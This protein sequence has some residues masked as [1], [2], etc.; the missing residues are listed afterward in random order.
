LGRTQKETL[1]ATV[2]SAAGTPSGTVTFFDGGRTLGTGTLDAAGQAALTVSLGVGMHSLTASFLGNRAF[3]A[4]KSAAVTE[5]V[6]RATTA[7]ALG[8]SINPVGTGQ[9]VSFTA[10]VTAVAPG[11]GT[12]A[13]TVTF[14]DGTTILGTASVG[15]GGKATFATSFS[16]TG[17]HAIKAVYNGN[18][19]FA[20]S[21]RTVTEQVKLS[22][23]TAL[24]A[25]AS[26]VP[27]GEPVTFTAMVRAASGTGTQT[28]TI[29]VMDGKVVLADVTL[30]GGK[31]TWTWS[32]STTGSH[33][34]KAV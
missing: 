25:S 19:N 4:S 7:V 10:T 18:G 1:T 24:R 9:K 30:I 28:G 27:A 12:P 33:R 15:A 34:I 6:N 21:S 13:G 5:T 23:K 17:R 29:T 8:P 3:A 14:F 16:T 26:S 22:S 2:N 31:A 32:F 20:A 11:A